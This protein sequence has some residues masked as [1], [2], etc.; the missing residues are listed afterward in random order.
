MLGHLKGQI[1]ATQDIGYH[2]P[3]NV[4]EV[5]SWSFRNQNYQIEIKMSPFWLKVQICRY[6]L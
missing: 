1:R 2:F 6:G 3:V 4:G 5:G